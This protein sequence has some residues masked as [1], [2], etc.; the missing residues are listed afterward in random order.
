MVGNQLGFLVGRQ[1]RNTLEVTTRPSDGIPKYS[2][3]DKPWKIRLVGLII[4]IYK[5][6]N[7]Y[8]I[9]S[10]SVDLEPSIRQAAHTPER[11][12]KKINR[13]KK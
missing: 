1:K 9:R 5:T 8:L 13:F 7:F 2:G 3:K 10:G 11:R 6:I 12:E 4:Y